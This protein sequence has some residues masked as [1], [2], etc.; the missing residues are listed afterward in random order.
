MID[1]DRI[2]KVGAFNF[3]RAYS[4][5]THEEAI[6]L[7]NGLQTIPMIKQNSIASHL[8]ADYRFM[9]IGLVLVAIKPLLKKGVNA[10][11]FIALRDKRLKKYKSSLLVV[12]QTNVCKSPIFCNCYPN[13][14]VDLTCPLRTE[15]LK[16]D[17]HVQGDEFHEFKNFVVLL[18]VYFRL[19]YKKQ[20]YYK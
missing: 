19:M 20:F 12:I 2:Y 16:L 13:F 18:R 15:A 9:H 5:K 17:V 1:I 4:I 3:M 6:S 14:T 10:P 8:K 11:I 7:Q